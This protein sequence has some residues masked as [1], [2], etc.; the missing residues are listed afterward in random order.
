MDRF[1]EGGGQVTVFT[2]KGKITA[3]RAVLAANAYSTQIPALSRY[4]MPFY[5]YI[6][7]TEP[8]TDEQWSRVGWTGREGMEDR[9][10][11]LHYFRPTVDGRMMWAGRDA[12]YRPNGPDPQYD[13]DDRVFKRLEETFAWTFPQLG[14]VKVAYR[15]GGPVGVTGTFLPSAG[16]LKGGRT[17]YAFG[18]CGH[19]VAITN[20]V[21]MAMRD[22]ILE[23]DTDYSRLAIV[24]KKP[25]NLGPRLIRDPMTRAMIR[26]QLE[27][28][29]IGRAT[30]QPL[31]AR[32]LERVAPATGTMNPTDKGS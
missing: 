2:P 30:K 14:D 12:P 16:W 4:V 8:L 28:D 15:W 26:H 11:F 10:V 17:A 18:F 27:Q 32:I 19:G 9:R 5:S 23:R 31:L 3:Q 22:L 21:A 6:L 24:G 20:L 1:E 13:R 7:L 29:D 25:L